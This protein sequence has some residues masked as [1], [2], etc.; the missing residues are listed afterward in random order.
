[1][2]GDRHEQLKA[3]RRAGLFISMAAWNFPAEDVSQGA[4][5]SFTP[6]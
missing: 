6:R 5:I 2:G 3:G 1:M 4:D